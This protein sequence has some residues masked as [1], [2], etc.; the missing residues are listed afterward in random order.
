MGEKQAGQIL[1]FEGSDLSTVRRSAHLRVSPKAWATVEN[2]RL[3]VDD[4]C[5]GDS[6]VTWVGRRRPTADYDDLGYVGCRIVP[7]IR[8]A[9][10]RPFRAAGCRL[11][12]DYLLGSCRIEQEKNDGSWLFSNSGRGVK[13]SVTSLPGSGF[14]PR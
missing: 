4:D 13:L 3:I 14:S 2:V 10:R 11:V 9:E 5:D 8:L 1:R 7:P 12:L 6:A